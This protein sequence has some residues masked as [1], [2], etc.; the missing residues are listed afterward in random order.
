MQREVPD[1]AMLAHQAF[2]FGCNN[3]CAC[4][5]AWNVFSKA[6]QQRGRLISGSVMR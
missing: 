1:R 6:L 2:S 3:D 4:A 5:A